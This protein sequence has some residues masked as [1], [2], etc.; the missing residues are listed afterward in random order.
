MAAQSTTAM[1]SV[2]PGDSVNPQTAGSVSQEPGTEATHGGWTGY[3]PLLQRN[4]PSWEEY[5]ISDNVRN[6]SAGTQG[7]GEGLAIRAWVVDAK[8]WQ[9]I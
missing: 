8:A 1:G 3:T 9:W 2:T 5:D 4:Y 6:P 7:F